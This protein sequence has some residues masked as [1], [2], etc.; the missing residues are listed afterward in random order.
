MI[1]NQ[2]AALVQLAVS[3]HHG[4]TTVDAVFALEAWGHH[5]L[6]SSADYLYTPTRCS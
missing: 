3:R 4:G 2:R 5:H 6:L 1:Q